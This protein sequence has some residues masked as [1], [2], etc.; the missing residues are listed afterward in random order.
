MLSCQATQPCHLL[1]EVQRASPY[2]CLPCLPLLPNPS[3]TRVHLAIF[4]PY[5]L[6]QVPSLDPAAGRRLWGAA[7]A[8]VAEACLEGFARCKRCSLEGRAGMSLDLQV[9][10]GQGAGRGRA[11]HVPDL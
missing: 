9:R 6:P 11:Q 7:A 5:A 10:A 4:P 1:V 2:L 3:P 8:H